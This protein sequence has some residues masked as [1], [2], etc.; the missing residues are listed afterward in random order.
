VQARPCCAATAIF[1]KGWA[2]L[3]LGNLEAT[4]PHRSVG[5][6]GQVRCEKSPKICDAFTFRSR[7]DI[8]WSLFITRP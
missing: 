6:R 2:Y 3:A 8:N 7:P 5:L 4:L 1:C